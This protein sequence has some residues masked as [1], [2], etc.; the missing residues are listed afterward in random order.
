MA[1]VPEGGGGGGRRK[2]PPVPQVTTAVPAPKSPIPISTPASRAA[3]KAPA[4][5]RGLPNSAAPKSPVAAD[6][7]QQVAAAPAGSQIKDILDFGMQFRGTPYVWGGAAPGGFDCSGLL[8]YMFKKAGV[9]I[10]RVSGDQARAGVGVAPKDARPGDLIAL[11]WSSRKSGSSPVDHIGVYIG[12]GMMLVAPR[13]G[14]VVKVQ[15]IDLTKAYSI[16]R[17]MPD[18]AYESLKQPNGQYVYA[19]AQGVRAAPAATPRNSGPAA[20]GG[21][22]ASNPQ[23]MGGAAEAAAAAG[24]TGATSF[25]MGGPPDV[26]GPDGKIDPIKAMQTYGYVYELANSVPELKTVLSKA[27]TEGWSANRFAAEVQNTKW[28]KSTNDNQRRVLELQKTNPGEYSRQLQQKADEIVIASRNLGIP[29]DNAKIKKLAERALSLGW[30]PQE[31]QRY[32]AAEVKV[33]ETGNTGA[34]A[35]TVDSLKEQAAQYGVPMSLPTLQQWTTQILRGMVPAA[36]FQSYLKEQAKSL[37]PG[38]SAA[39]DAGISVQQYVEPYRQITAQT[40][41]LN[42][43]D[44]RLDN[45]HMQKALYAVGKDGARTQMTLSEYTQYLRE[46]PD[47]RKTRQ[48]QESAASLTETITQMFGATA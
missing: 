15:K 42:P 27:I 23:G 4:P 40:L 16:R 2:T 12:N 46:T 8:Y 11:D 43:N 26:F 10:P 25:D 17:V 37:F 34:T 47:F 19:N 6:R 20:G 7:A 5:T 9:N 48:A 31:L 24:I 18:S 35:V 41:E 36:A 21:D 45:T 38:L 22:P 29:Q 13:T 44:L 28:W 1:I 32:V 39:I 33:Q 3:K 14:D 30:S